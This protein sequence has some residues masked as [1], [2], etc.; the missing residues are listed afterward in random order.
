[1]KE[2]VH[3]GRVIAVWLCIGLLLAC[4][5]VAASAE[6]SADER[7]PAYPICYQQNDPRWGSREQ[8]AP[9]GCGILSLVNAVHFLTGNF[10]NP[11]E[12][13]AYAR[14]ID[15]Y[16]GSVGG[17][18]A[19]WVLYHQLEDYEK[20]YGF[21]V[22]Q[23]GKDA[24]AKHQMLL[25]HLAAGG[26]AVAHVK[27]HF[28]AL[29]GYD[30]ATDSMLVYDCAAT[31]DRQTTVEPQWKTTEFLS[32]HPR[33][34]VDW[35]CLISR[36][37]STTVTVEESNE[38]GND[39]ELYPTVWHG[40]TEGEPLVLRGSVRHRAE[41]ESFFCVIDYDYDHV[42]EL[43][44][45][46]KEGRMTSFA[47]PVD[48]SGLKR[49]QHT[50]RLSARGRDGS[51][52]DLAEYTLFV[53]DGADGYDAAAGS[54]TINMSGYA[55][56]EGIRTASSALAY[57]GYVFRSTPESVLYLGK[58]DLSKYTAVRFYYSAREEF[59]GDRQAL[60]GLRASPSSFGFRDS[61]VDMSGAVA[62][63]DIP[64]ADHPLSAVQAV[65]VDLTDCDYS[66]DLWLSVYHPQRQPF[67]LRKICF[68]TGDVPAF[69][70]ITQGEESESATEPTSA[71]PSE[72]TADGGD[73]QTVHGCSA[74]ASEGF[75][76]LS[77]WLGLCALLCALRKKSKH[78]GK[79]PSC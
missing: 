30:P 29:C 66:G 60:L 6:G 59:F 8:L 76:T 47:V 5:P 26:T 63:G 19:R 36:T 34:T 48:L 38:T 68:Y 54:L 13:A 77:L 69:E 51:V 18:I 32:T 53:T 2:L 40:G 71:L 49:G 11:V 7:E 44:G 72:G 37:G 79:H 4:L 22:V 55:G 1:M 61:D 12:L 23:T 46:I 45:E 21:D 65:T 73:A 17:G 64:T 28:I 25:E 15:A 42:I 74:Q 9:G 10:I 62:M 31:P 39:R 20:K 24:G 58:L 16:Y 27:G 75:G 78:G 50:L 35:W 52:V 43:T 56:Q 3:I 57:D 67:Y 41:V 14:S 70:V 33:M